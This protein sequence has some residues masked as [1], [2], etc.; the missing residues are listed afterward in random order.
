MKRKNGLLEF[1]CLMDMSEHNCLCLVYALQHVTF[2]P[3]SSLPFAMLRL[4]SLII[5]LSA[6]YLVLFKYFYD[7][8][9]NPFVDEEL[10]VSTL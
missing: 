7:M 1:F 2:V 4:E 6:G 8:M 10:I 5:D 9:T 3:E